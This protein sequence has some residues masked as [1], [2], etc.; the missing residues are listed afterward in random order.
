MEEDKFS[1]SLTE[2]EIVFVLNTLSEKPF[3]QVA[4]LVINISDQLKAY[5]SD[6]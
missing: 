2:E 4:N 3:G 6:G 5:K 1:I